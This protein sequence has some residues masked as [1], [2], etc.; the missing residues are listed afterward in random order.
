MKVLGI[1]FS[2]LKKIILIFTMEVSPNHNRF[3]TDFLKTFF[4]STGKGGFTGRL[5]FT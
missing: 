1:F 4:W 2:Y 5:S 3:C